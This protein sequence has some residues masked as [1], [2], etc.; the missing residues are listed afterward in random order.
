MRCAKN[1]L[2]TINYVCTV[3]TNSKNC[4]RIEIKKNGA[5]WRCLKQNFSERLRWGQLKESIQRLDENNEHGLLSWWSDFNFEMHILC[6]RV[7]PVDNESEQR[8]TTSQMSVNWEHTS[9]AMQCNETT[10]LFLSS[11]HKKKRCAKREIDKS[12]TAKWLCGAKIISLVAIVCGV[13]CM[14]QMWKMM[15]ELSR[16]NK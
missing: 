1:Y 10:I 9:N 12:K 8:P 2:Y 11:Y 7:A 3:A 15:G 16:S 4:L 6:W 5:F 13:V 14:E